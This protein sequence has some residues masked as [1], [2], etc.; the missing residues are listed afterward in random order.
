MRIFTLRD[1]GDTSFAICP[2]KE[3]RLCFADY[4]RNEND[5]PVTIVRRV[6]IQRVNK[7]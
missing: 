3:N 6:R 7:N 4:R 2:I 5:V 1:K